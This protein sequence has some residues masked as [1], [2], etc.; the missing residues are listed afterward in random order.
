MRYSLTLYLLSVA[1]TSVACTKIPAFSIRDAQM[2]SSIRIRNLDDFYP[3]LL[4]RT[5]SKG[6]TKPSRPSLATSRSQSPKNSGLAPLP[7][8]TPDTKSMPAASP[9]AGFGSPAV[10]GIRNPAADLDSPGSKSAASSRFD[11]F[12]TPRHPGSARYLR[13]DGKHQG[14]PS[15]PVAGSDDMAYTTAAGRVMP[16]RFSNREMIEAWNEF[17]EPSPVPFGLRPVRMSKQDVRKAGFSPASDIESKPSSPASA[18]DR[19]S[20]NHSV[21]P[22]LISFPNVSSNSLPKKNQE[23]SQSL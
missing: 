15:P 13:S 7:P 11:T 10:P 6:T 18:T 3:L 1:G 20:F 4:P 19:S 12:N 8:V 9:I 23:K 21:S 17:R 5:K 22:R 14:S 2:D 16:G